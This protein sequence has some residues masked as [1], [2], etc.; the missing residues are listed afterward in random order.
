VFLAAPMLVAATVSALYDQVVN[1]LVKSP[2]LRPQYQQHP[3]HMLQQ[4][5]PLSSGAGLNGSCALFGSVASR[6][7][8]MQLDHVLGHSVCPLKYLWL[9]VNQ[10]GI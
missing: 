7:E 2:Q 9:N 4:Q 5:P 6:K 8:C 10:E 1:R 3:P